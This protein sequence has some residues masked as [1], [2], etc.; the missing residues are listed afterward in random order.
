MF[1][2]DVGGDADSDEDFEAEGSHYVSLYE[3]EGSNIRPL[4]EVVFS[5]APLQA[6]VH[7]PVDLVPFH[8]ALTSHHPVSLDLD[9]QHGSCF[10]TAGSPRH[11]LPLY[12][13]RLRR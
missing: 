7:I 10:H 6:V 13:S 9:R 12:P 5:T 8:P 3:N 11:N 2:V 4:S 1:V